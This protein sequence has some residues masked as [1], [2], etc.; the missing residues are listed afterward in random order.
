VRLVGW[1]LAWALPG[2][3]DGL[4]IRPLTSADA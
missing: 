1:W 2:F 4:Q 3:L